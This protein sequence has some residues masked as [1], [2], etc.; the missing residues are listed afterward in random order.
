MQVSTKKGRLTARHDQLPF[1]VRRIGH[2]S[3]GRE[4]RKEPQGSSTACIQTMLV[5]K[6]NDQPGCKVSSSLQES[7]REKKME[8]EKKS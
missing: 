5:T 6:N 8:G 4:G 3:G 2:E 7:T 1:E